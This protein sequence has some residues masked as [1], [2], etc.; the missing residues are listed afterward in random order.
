VD[1]KY[2][3]AGEFGAAARLSPKALRLYAEQ[4]LLVPISVDPATGYRCYDPDK[5]P[6]A[7]DCRWPGS[8]SWPTSP[9]RLGHWSCVDG[10]GPSARCSTNARPWW[11][12]WNGR[13]I[14]S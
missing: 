8:D 2:L 11:R 12:R 6:R 9:R 13:S 10:C 3:R 1:K 4:G 7:R 14:P 5:L